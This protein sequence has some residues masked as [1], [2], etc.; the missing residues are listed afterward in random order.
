MKKLF[1][2]ISILPL[3]LGEG[4]MAAKKV[5]QV[6]AIAEFDYSETEVEVLIG[7][8]I[9]E[10]Y[11]DKPVFKVVSVS[12]EGKELELRYIDFELT[13]GSA[14]CTGASS[15]ECSKVYRHHLFNINMKWSPDV[16][17]I[18]IFRGDK[19]LAEAKVVHPKGKKAADG[20]ESARNPKND[21]TAPPTR[22]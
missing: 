19:L 15:A 1:F 22:K 20:T 14:N 10:T 21:L 7:D 2:L 12:K 5:I 16:D 18:K 3:S 4:A 17:K 9:D 13:V 11:I 6:T 8:P